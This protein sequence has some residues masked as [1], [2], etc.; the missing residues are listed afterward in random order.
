MSDFV[1]RFSGIKLTKEQEQRLGSAIQA[2]VFKEFSKLAEHDG[3]RV[4]HVGLPRD[5]IGLIAAY[6]ADLKSFESLMQSRATVEFK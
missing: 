3:K 6:E 4:V 1:V 5:W 2:A